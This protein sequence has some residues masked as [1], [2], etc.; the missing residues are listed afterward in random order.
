MNKFIILALIL[1]V[2]YFPTSHA[3]LRNLK[4][5][6]TP[7]VKSPKKPKSPNSE[8]SPKEAKPPKEPKAPKSKPVKPP[9]TK[10]KGKQ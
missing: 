2:S 4:M 8:K 1:F 5:G 6:M 7:T 3:E 9:S 10:G